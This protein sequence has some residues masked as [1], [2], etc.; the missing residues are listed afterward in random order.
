MTTYRVDHD[1][2]YG[3]PIIVKVNDNG[4]EESQAPTPDGSGKL[5]AGFDAWNATQ[6]PPLV[7]A[8]VPPASQPHPSFDYAKPFT[9]NKELWVQ[10]LKAMDDARAPFV[11]DPTTTGQ[12]ILANLRAQVKAVVAV[13]APAPQG[14]KN[15]LIQARVLAG[16]S[17]PEPLIPTTVDTMLAPELRI[18]IDVCEKAAIKG[19]GLVSLAAL[20]QE[21]LDNGG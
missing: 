8:I 11:V 3:W 16:S 4:S 13:L 20:F 12:T 7:V 6:V 21:S 2:M 14:I 18:I 10:M 17:T 15:A 9:N 1:S 5:R 19:A